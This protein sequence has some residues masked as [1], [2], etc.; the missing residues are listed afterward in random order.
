MRAARLN[1]IGQPL[2]IEDIASPDLSLSAVKVRIQASP[3]PSH[4]TS[5]V[6]GQMPFALP[7]P[8][9]MGTS[10][11]AV[12]E[13]VADDVVGLEPGQLVYCSPYHFVEV[14][15]LGREE[16]L[17]GFFGMTPNSDRLLKR[18]KN[19]TFAE[20]AIFPQEC[21]TPL[22]G[23]ENEQSTR[24]AAINYLNIAYGGLLKG[25]MRPGL[26]VLVTGATGYLGSLV[27][28]TALAMGAAKVFPVG[29]SH[30]ILEKLAAI[31][32]KRVVPVPLS[33]DSNNYTTEIAKVAGKVDLYIDSLGL[34]PT[35]EL[36]MAGINAVRLG[37]TVVLNGGVFATLPIN[38]L[39]I[40]G[41]QLTIRGNFMF[42]RTAPA[43][44]AQMIA[45]G[46]IGLEAIQV[47]SFGLEQVNEAIASAATAKA[48]ELVVVAP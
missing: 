30:S 13:A 32:P 16:I 5:V 14:N 44:V 36:T 40:L 12:V 43:E 19:G 15:G 6:Q 18:W 37:G 42:P 21:V 27:V 7:I 33:S 47:K 46:L 11:I 31:D 34:L 22:K 17:I 48:L 29:R 41:K 4:T 3:I 9:T 10:A 2:T 26:N 35:P 24:L 28:L 39:D 38:Y 1:V 25:G 23:L 8:Y 45:A 20:W